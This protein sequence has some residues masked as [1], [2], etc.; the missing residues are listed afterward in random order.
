MLH[1]DATGS[2]QTTT[3]AGAYSAPFRTRNPVPAAKNVTLAEQ[4]AVHWHCRSFPRA[5][6]AATR[7]QWSMTPRKNTNAWGWATVKAFEKHRLTRFTRLH[8]LCV[9]QRWGHIL[10]FASGCGLAARNGRGACGRCSRRDQVCLRVRM[11]TM[12]AQSQAEHWRKKCDSEAQEELRL[13]FFPCRMRLT[14]G[15]SRTRGHSK[16]AVAARSVSCSERRRSH[17][18]RAR[19]MKCC[20]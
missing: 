3:E 5:H 16:A 11:S 4:L 19:K 10:D 13:Q 9:A 2:T 18:L 14:H 8:L 7:S 6:A 20:T 12:L 15:S 1:F 17:Q